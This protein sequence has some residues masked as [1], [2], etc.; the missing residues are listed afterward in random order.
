MNNAVKKKKKHFKHLNPAN[1]KENL[2][3]EKLS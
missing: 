1:P 3:R 2:K